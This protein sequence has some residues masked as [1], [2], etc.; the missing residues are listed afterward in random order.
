[1]EDL[2][3]PCRGRTSL[4]SSRAARS[5]TGFRGFR[6]QQHFYFTFLCAPNIALDGG[7]G[8]TRENAQLVHPRQPISSSSG[9]LPLCALSPDAVPPPIEPLSLLQAVGIRWD[10]LG[11]RWARTLCVASAFCFLGEEVPSEPASDLASY[12]MFTQAKFL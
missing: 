3:A 9:A 5:E 7:A 10:A 8:G 12:P 4:E 1:M 6:C 2:T 11:T